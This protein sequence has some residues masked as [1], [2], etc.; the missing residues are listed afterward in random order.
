MYVARKAILGREEPTALSRALTFVFDEY[1]PSFFWWEIL[2]MLRRFLLVG[3]MSIVLEGSVVQLMIA[4]LFC[5]LYLIVQ[6]QARPFKEAGDEYVALV[7]SASLAVLDLCCVV[8]KVGVLAET[9]E[10]HKILPP[11][12]RDRFLV[13]NALLSVVTFTSI[14]C[15]LIVSIA[16]T[17]HQAFQD[18]RRKMQERRAED[19][20]RQYSLEVPAEK[21]DLGVRTATLTRSP[22]LD[23]DAL[24][25]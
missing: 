24:T 14:V 19:R 25:A 21:A 22:S 16:I 4:S 3:L 20:A 5:I 15:S 8:I 12:L 1:R 18:W 9:P 23:E 10:V 13:P 7:S 17:L 11:R 6:L 2:E